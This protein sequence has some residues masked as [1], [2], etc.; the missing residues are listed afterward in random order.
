MNTDEQVPTLRVVR[1][2]ATDEELAAVVAVITGR[3]GVA[4]DGEPESAPASA[5]TDRSALVRAPV[6]P[7]PGAW[8]ASAWRQ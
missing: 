3:S 8:R 6:R 1:G 5:W 4:D 2:T 7:G